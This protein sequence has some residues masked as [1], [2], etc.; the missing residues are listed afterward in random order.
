MGDPQSLRS[1]KARPNWRRTCSCH[2]ASWKKSGTQQPSGRVFWVNQQFDEWL[3]T[4]G[5]LN[6]VKYGL[7]DMNM[8]YKPLN[9]WDAHPSGTVMICRCVLFSLNS[10]SSLRFKKVLLG[11]VLPAVIVQ[12][13]V[14]FSMPFEGKA[15]PWP[16]TFS[17]MSLATLATQQIGLVAVAVKI[18]MATFLM[19]N[20]QKSIK[21]RKWINVRWGVSC[22]T[23]LLWEKPG[24]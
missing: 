14:C 7:Y 13:A 20:Y 8:D 18:Q 16:H 1:S 22:S 10:L 6:L 19:A 4:P 23:F 15:H 21:G 5:F 3:K 17:L 12:V 9:K 2:S 24:G 11:G